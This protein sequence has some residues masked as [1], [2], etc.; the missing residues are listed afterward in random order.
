MA[1]NDT[2]YRGDE[3][4]YTRFLTE[5]LIR[6]TQA[7]VRERRCADAV[8]CTRL[9]H[10]RRIPLVEAKDDVLLEEGLVGT[11]EVTLADRRSGRVISQFTLERRAEGIR[12]RGETLDD[13]RVQLMRDL[14]RDTVVRLQGISLLAARGY[15][16]GTWDTRPAR[17]GRAP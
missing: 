11:V 15:P 6:N 10:L 14:A 3:F 4:V 7:Q 2:F 5:E 8:L 12:P 16:T 13:E 17:Q 1:K 9:L